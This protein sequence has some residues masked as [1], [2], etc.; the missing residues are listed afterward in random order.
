VTFWRI[1]MLLK[2]ARAIV[3]EARYIEALKVIA[4]AAEAA[5]AVKVETETIDDN[6]DN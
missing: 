4:E 6:E 2:H 5:E 3:N 1:K